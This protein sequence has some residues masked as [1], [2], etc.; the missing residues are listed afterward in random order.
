MRSALFILALACVGAS[1]AAQVASVT[2][3]K[4]VQAGT[5]DRDPLTTSLEQIPPDFRQDDAFQGLYEIPGGR[6]GSGRFMRTAG[7]LH[8]V[9]PRS[10]YVN[11][12]FGEM[13][14]VPAGT[15]FYIGPPPSDEV[16]QRPERSAAPAPETRGAID[17]RVYEATRI[18]TSISSQARGRTVWSVTPPSESPSVGVNDEDYRDALLRRLSE[19]EIKRIEAPSVT[20]AAVGARAEPPGVP[21]RTDSTRTN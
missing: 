11:T 15:V 17:N 5:K 8:A 1:A 20:E 4:R 10:E 9:F 18:D 19:R 7:G 6:G 2:A 21:P 12:G 3:P 14:V 13:P 16:P